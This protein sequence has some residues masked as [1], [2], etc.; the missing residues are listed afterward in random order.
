MNLPDPKSWVIGVSQV[1]ANVGLVAVAKRNQ[2]P[3][4]RLGMSQWDDLVAQGIAAREGLEGLQ[5]NLGDLALTVE[6]VWNEQATCSAGS[7]PTK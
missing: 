2:R 5:W 1:R 6:R 4:G 3:I 7:K